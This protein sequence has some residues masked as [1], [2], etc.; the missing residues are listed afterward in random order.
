M[1][2]APEVGAD[3]LAM[4]DVRPPEQFAGRSPAST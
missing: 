2:V 4:L 1:T 3:H